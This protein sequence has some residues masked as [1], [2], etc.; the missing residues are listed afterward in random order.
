MS[1]TRTEPFEAWI[2]SLDF[3]PSA[4]EA[5]RAGWRANE[6]SLPTREQ[7]A[8]ALYLDDADHEDWAWAT[9]ES[10]MARAAYLKNAD[11]VLALLQKGADR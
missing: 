6:P 8:E 7:I 3:D 9:E 1:T 5:F 10:E 4:T 2:S 11:A